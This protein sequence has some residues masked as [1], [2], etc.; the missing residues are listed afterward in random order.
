MEKNA[1]EKS[2][3]SNR[4]LAALMF[5]DMVGYSAIAH[6]NEILARSLVSEQRTLIRASLAKHGGKEHDTA[7]DGFFIEFASAVDALNCAV[8]IQ[9]VLFDRNRSASLERQIV[10]RVGLHLGDIVSDGAGLFG[11]GVNLAARIEPFAP[12]GGICL[13]QQMFDQVNGK[14]PGL[15]Y[16]KRG[17][18]ELKNIAS[19]A[20]IYSVLMPWTQTHESRFSAAKRTLSSLPIFENI[21]SIS[22]AALFTLCF[23]CLVFSSYRAYTFE[24]EPLKEAADRS[25]ASV[26]DFS[27]AKSRVDLSEGW[28]YQ[29]APL[30]DRQVGSQSP[31]AVGWKTFDP[32]N[33]WR[34]SED[35]R[36]PYWLEKKFALSK[37]LETP[38]LVLGQIAGNHRVYLNGKFIGGA[39]GASDLS[40]YTFAADSISTAGENTILIAVDGRPSLNPG[41]T[42]ISTVGTFM[43]DYREVRGLVE[44][45]RLKF[46]ILRNVF[47][48]ISIFIFVIALAYSIFRRSSKTYFYYA[49]ILLLGSVQLAYFNPLMNVAFDY[50]F[51]RFLRTLGLTITP[52]ILMS[53]FLTM[54][55]RRKMLRAETLNNVFAAVFTGFAALL[56]FRYS[57]TTHDFAEHFNWLLAFGITYSATALLLVAVS[58]IKSLSKPSVRKL[59]L[60]KTSFYFAFEFAALLALASALKRGAVSGILSPSL[61]DLIVQSTLATP[62][63]FALAVMVIATLD[64]IRQ[65]TSAQFQKRRDE[66]AREIL[67]LVHDSTATVVT[68]R[69]IHEKLCAFMQA[70]RS[71]LYSVDG[72]GPESALRLANSVGR[73]LSKG[74]LS[75]SSLKSHRI[76]SHVLETQTPI[77]IRNIKSDLRFFD[78]K[79]DEVDQ[80]SSYRTGSCMVIPMRT[81]GRCVGLLTFADRRDHQVFTDSDFSTALEMASML[82]LLLSAQENVVIGSVTCRSQ[83][84]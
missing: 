17:H 66:F 9:G 6:A 56:L 43:G 36:G 84:S 7:G 14:I 58:G 45:N 32:R 57:P 64:H 25:P 80:A 76:L 4:R 29:L 49:F 2:V 69:L 51:L 44:Q 82:A 30:S 42:S 67:H 21:N 63:L 46:S 41:L 62:F 18:R 83:A 71:T 59:Q 27:P 65:S 40:S 53:A 24:S 5:T 61:R 38:A 68:T 20:V 54:D 78:R 28:F 16:K 15:A 26:E 33:T 13:T 10:L 77:H 74:D 37:R 3:M 39:E 35:L 19:G 73:Q 81:L 47:F 50:P 70:T 31:L 55:S 48:A 8:E 1:E 22:S 72:N 12:H 11:N 52:M 75:A 60:I 79:P 34:Y 23:V